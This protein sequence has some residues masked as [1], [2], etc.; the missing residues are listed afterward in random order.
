[1][2]WTLIY[3]G[4]RLV[5]LSQVTNRKMG[6]LNRKDTEILKVTYFSSAFPKLGRVFKIL[7][8]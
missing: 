5:T 8:N 4:L 2:G 7:Y 3:K 1:M 6:I